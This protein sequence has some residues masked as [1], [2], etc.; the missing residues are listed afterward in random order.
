MPPAAG[1][2]TPPAG[3]GAPTPTSLP[4]PTHSA[5]ART[6]ASASRTCGGA[7]L[8]YSI[9]SLSY[10]LF[11][12]VDGALRMIV[13]LHAYSLGFSAL[14]LAAVFAGYEAAGVAVN[15]LAGMA[16]A[17]FGIKATLMA[18]LTAQLVALGALFAWQRGWAPGAP[19]PIV[20]LAAIQVLSGCA[21][22]RSRK[23]GGERITPRPAISLSLISL[24]SLLIL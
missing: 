11:T 5:W 23:K 13:L 10:I 16:G 14:T 22:V 9:I 6:K 17:R 20:Y 19:G 8:P 24:S 7:L 2:T 15:L 12:T 18:G 3:D 1:T 4:P 21:K